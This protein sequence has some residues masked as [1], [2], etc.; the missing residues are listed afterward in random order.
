[1]TQSPDESINST[2]RCFF[3]VVIPFKLKFKNFKFKSNRPAKTNRW[4]SFNKTNYRRVDLN[5]INKRHVVS[6]TCPQHVNSSPFPSANRKP[7]P[8]PLR[9][10]T[11]IGENH[12]Q[13][14]KSLKNIDVT[15]TQILEIPYAPP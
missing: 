6:S 7:K 1:M 15:S 12:L 9:I 8:K 3:Y 2:G 10:S 5:K 11:Q 13:I 14:S 4:R